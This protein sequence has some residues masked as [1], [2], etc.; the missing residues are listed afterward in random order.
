MNQGRLGT[1]EQ[2]RPSL[3][4]TGDHDDSTAQAQGLLKDLFTTRMLTTARGRFLVS[5]LSVGARTTRGDDPRQRTRLARLFSDDLE[6]FRIPRRR[7][8][9]I[10]AVLRHRTHTGDRGCLLSELPPQD[11]QRWAEIAGTRFA[12]PGLYIYGRHDP[13]IIPEFTPHLDDVFDD[14]RLEQLEASHF[15]PEE[16]PAEVASLIRAFVEQNA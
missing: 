9:R 15:V 2:Q 1:V 12:M 11:K 6:R 14:I 16:K 3:T 5:V 10:R 7:A 8:G 13:V 4:L